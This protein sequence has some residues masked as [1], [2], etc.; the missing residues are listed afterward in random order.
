MNFEHIILEKDEGIATITLNRPESLN[1]LS[2]KMVEELPIAIENVSKDSSIGALIVTGNGRAFSVGGDV[3]AMATKPTLMGGR[4][5]LRE[6]YNGAIHALVNLG[7]P[8]IAGVNGFAIGAGLS[9]ALCCDILVASEEAKFSMP[10]FRVGLVP[11]MGAHYFLPRAIG[12]AKAKEFIFTQEMIDAKEAERIGLVNKVVPAGELKT[13]VR[14]LAS[15]LAKLPPKALSMSK[16]ILNKTA[17][18]NLEAVLEYECYAQGMLM[19]SE[20]HKEA[21]QAFL[22]KREPKFTGE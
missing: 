11:D 8:V 6:F 17:E 21:I 3:K 13:V 18:M 20:D 10:F 19:Q 9:L 7:K 12:L 4:E 14:T 5:N 1:A 22:D 16:A 15:Q 2:D